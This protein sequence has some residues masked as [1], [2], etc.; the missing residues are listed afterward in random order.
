VAPAN[1]REGI[2][3]HRIH[4]RARIYGVHKGTQ[5]LDKEERRKKDVDAK[6]SHEKPDVFFL[7]IVI[8]VILK[9]EIIRPKNISFYI[10]KAIRL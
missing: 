3:K 8:D 10:S 6:G 1:G 7:L 4:F 9:Q 5:I 2:A